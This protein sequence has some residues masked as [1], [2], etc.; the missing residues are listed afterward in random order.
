[1]RQ[2][3]DKERVNLKVVYLK[4]VKTEDS[5]PPP[6]RFRPA[7]WEVWSADLGMGA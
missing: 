1:M 6:P 7:S 2:L 4:S 5:P 3:V